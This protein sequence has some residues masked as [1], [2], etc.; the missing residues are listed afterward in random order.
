MNE[1]LL[2]RELSDLFATGPQRAPAKVVDT[3]IA[4]AV[5][6]AQHR[7]RLTLLDLRAWPP[8]PRSIADPGMQRSVRLALTLAIVALLTAAI[9]VVGSRLLDQPRIPASLVSAGALDAPYRGP[10]L[11]ALPDGRLLVLGHG[12]YDQVATFFDPRT[13]E[14]SGGV[15]FG[16]PFAASPGAYALPDGRVLLIGS[17]A[18][19]IEVEGTTAIGWLDLATGSATVAGRLLVDRFGGAPVVLADGRVLVTGG[20]DFGDASSATLASVEVLLPDRAVFASALPMAQPRLRHSTL[21]L[22]DG[23]VLIVGG[24][25]PGGVGFMADVLEVEVYDPD[26]D[27]STVTGAP[28]PVTGSTVVGT[29]GPGRGLTAGPPV[30]LADGKVLIPGGAER[31]QACGEYFLGQQVM[32]RFDPETQELATLA[33]LPHIVENAVALADG[34]VLVFGSYLTSPGGCDSGIEPVAVPWLGIFDPGTGVTLET[35]NPT[36]GA[37]TLSIEITRRYDSGAL[38]PEGRVAL[39]SDDFDVPTGNPIDLFT[40]PTR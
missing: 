26:P 40:V 34:R 35:T 27:L 2:D 28:T 25:G 13:G 30:R 36:T 31:I 22:D 5:G 39:I 14:A 18:S 10:R 19:D 33:P 15:S 38:L 7:A 29:I 9:V 6:I 8:H 12:G 1:I 4:Q 16:E 11:T 21:L 32:Y 17:L 23:R 3:A 37:S 20:A 24:S